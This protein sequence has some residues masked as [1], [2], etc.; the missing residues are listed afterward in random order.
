MST[1]TTTSLS[2]RIVEILATHLPYRLQRRL[3]ARLAVPL[4]ARRGYER[5]DTADRAEWVVDDAIVVSAYWLRF[6]DEHGP[7]ISVH[8]R[9]EEL[10]RIDCLN[11]NPHVHYGHA[12]SLHRHGHGRV[13]LPE[14][15]AETLIERAEYELTNN[16]AFSLHLHRSRRAQQHP[17][18]RSRLAAIGAEAA[19]HL[20]ELVAT[21]GFD[22]LPENTAPE[23]IDSPAQ[24][25][26]APTIDR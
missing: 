11:R 21:H 2:D 24:D 5:T 15:T 18:D 4:L 13:W 19:A 17:I 3:P 26:P 8:F 6:C 16:L 20:R 22:G 14:R 9:D 12:E 10:M 23:G 1:D 7:A 25:R